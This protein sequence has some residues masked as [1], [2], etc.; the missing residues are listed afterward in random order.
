MIPI[1][2]GTALGGI[3]IVRLIP[4]RPHRY[5]RLAIAGIGGLYLLF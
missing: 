5:F 3:R 1:T 2:Y 4:E